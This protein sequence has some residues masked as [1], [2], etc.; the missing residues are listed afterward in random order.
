MVQVMNLFMHLNMIQ[1]IYLSD[2]FFNQFNITGKSNLMDAISFVLGEST[3]NLRVK[4]L[5]VYEF[6][7]SVI[8]FIG[9]HLRI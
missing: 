8:L 4:R 2:M 6:F 1:L 3:K 7:E 9:N 5:N